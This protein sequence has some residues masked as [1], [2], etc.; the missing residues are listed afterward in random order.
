MKVAPHVKMPRIKYNWLQIEEMQR[1]RARKRFS[2]DYLLWRAV[3]VW[4][5]VGVMVYSWLKRTQLSAPFEHAGTKFSRACCPVNKNEYT[6][7]AS[8]YND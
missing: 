6:R 5:L 7:Q 4:V 8:S 1:Q 3:L 2:R